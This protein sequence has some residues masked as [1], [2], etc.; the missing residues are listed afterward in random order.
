MEELGRTILDS[1]KLIDN[2]QKSI[3]YEG[4]AIRA[5]ELGDSWLALHSQV[6]ADAST[7][8]VLAEPYEASEASLAKIEKAIAD[9]FKSKSKSSKNVYSAIVVVESFRKTLLK[10]LDSNAALLLKEMLSELDH[11]V[12]MEVSAKN[13]EDSLGQ[14]RF[15]SIDGYDYIRRKQDEATR[16]YIQAINHKNT[17]PAKSVVFLYQGDLAVFESWLI[18]QSVMLNDSSYVVAALRWSLASAALNNLE[19]LPNNPKS[20]AREIRKAL[21]WAVGPENAKSLS[22]YLLKF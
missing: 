7:Y 19:G 11:L 4:L 15:S 20:A 9:S 6:L 16:L 5:A 22:K 17:E 13:I 3:S 21:L 2:K 12:E 8:K 14:H 18:S 10:N 1:I